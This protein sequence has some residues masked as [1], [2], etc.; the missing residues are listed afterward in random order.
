[1]SNFLGPVTKD[2]LM[3]TLYPTCSRVFR[4]LKAGAANSTVP[5]LSSV[6]SVFDD[7]F[8]VINQI[9]FKGSQ[10]TMQMN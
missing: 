7:D 5:F 3:I 10:S 4:R 1:M 2:E 8:S 9:S 6:S